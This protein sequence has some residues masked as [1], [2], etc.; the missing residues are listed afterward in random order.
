MK[1]SEPL[2]QPE[3]GWGVAF[4]SQRFRIGHGDWTEELAQSRPNTHVL[5]KLDNRK[6]FE[7]SQL[8]S[9]LYVML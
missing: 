6:S 3:L 7:Q 9:M 8:Y 2:R 5:S 1:T 4:R